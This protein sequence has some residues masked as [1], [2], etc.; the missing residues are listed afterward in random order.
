MTTGERRNPYIDD[1]KLCGDDGCGAICGRCTGH[2][3]DHF[4]PVTNRRWHNW[5]NRAYGPGE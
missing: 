4:D 2:D 3:G 5:A 1:E